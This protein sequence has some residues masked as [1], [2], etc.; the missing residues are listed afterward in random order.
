M[1]HG[2]R[3]GRVESIA[4][5]ARGMGEARKVEWDG[6]MLRGAE[7]RG[8]MAQL[9]REDRGGQTLSRRTRPAA[10]GRTRSLVQV[11]HLWWGSASVGSKAG[12]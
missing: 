10:T 9:V 7:G 8:R 2:A 11:P 5:A 4:D 6:G 3:V 1:G 12:V